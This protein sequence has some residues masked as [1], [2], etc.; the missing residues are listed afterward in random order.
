MEEES[1]VLRPKRPKGEDGYKIF[2]VR[3]REELV[4]RMDRIAAQTGYS[5]NELIGRFLQ[6]ALDHCVIDDAPD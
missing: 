3:L 5:R 4:G 1:L 6:Y 2:S